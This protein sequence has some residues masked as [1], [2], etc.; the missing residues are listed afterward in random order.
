MVKQDAIG[1]LAASFKRVA[2]L[3][4]KTAEKAEQPA[5]HVPEY[6]VE[7]GVRCVCQAFPAFSVALR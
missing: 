3:G 2:V 4:I 5:Y 7:Q 1:A 6:L